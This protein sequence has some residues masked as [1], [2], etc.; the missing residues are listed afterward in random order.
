MKQAISTD[1]MDSQR[2][3]RNI[4]NYSVHNLEKSTQNGQIP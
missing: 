4:I 1:F 2:H 3:W